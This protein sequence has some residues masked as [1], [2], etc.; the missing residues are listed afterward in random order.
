MAELAALTL[1]MVTI[2]PEMSDA[3]YCRSIPDA[4]RKHP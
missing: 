3:D 1:A 2:A 4:A